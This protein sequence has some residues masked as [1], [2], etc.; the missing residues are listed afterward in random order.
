MQDVHTTS[1]CNLFQ[2]LASAVVGSTALGDDSDDVPQETSSESASNQPNK[3][4]EST[5]YIVIGTKSGP[6]VAKPDWVSEIIDVSNRKNA[7]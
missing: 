2:V 6:E 7:D 3:L 5:N 1:V 4:G